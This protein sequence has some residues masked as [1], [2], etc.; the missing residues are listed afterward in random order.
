MK[1][2]GG[3]RPGAGRRAGSGR[4]GMEETRAVRVPVSAIPKIGVFLAQMRDEPQK[5]AVSASALVVDPPKRTIGEF[6][7]KVPAGSLGFDD[8]FADERCDLNEMLVRDAASTFL[9]TVAG[10]SMDRA[11]IFDGDKVL[12]DRSLEAQSGDVVVVVLAGE[13]QTI[14]RLRLSQD[15]V[16]LV[17]ES[18]N[19]THLPR[20]ILAG[21]E[22]AVW[23]V[24]TAVIRQYR[25][26]KAARRR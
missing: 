1:T 11:G 6:T 3:F 17:P 9:Y 25:R 19:P 10:D 22:W 23:G 20:K 18:N 7:V 21:E 13:G 5:E 26:T 24:V 16:V 14:K 8:G 2:H 15:S 12:V 4:F